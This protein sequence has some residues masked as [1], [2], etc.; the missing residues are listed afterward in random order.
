MNGIIEAK[1]QQNYAETQRK[2]KFCI[3]H[4]IIVEFNGK[5]YFPSGMSLRFKEP[6]G[7]FYTV[8]LTD[9][10]RLNST[11]TVGIDDVDWPEEGGG[12]RLAN[13]KATAQNVSGSSE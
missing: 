9:P 2:I 8:E 1:M 12:F 4:R 5:K 6:D 13:H 10:N 3:R 7:F 11:V